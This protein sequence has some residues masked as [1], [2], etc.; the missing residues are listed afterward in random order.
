MDGGRGTFL[1]LF[2]IANPK[3]DMVEANK[4]AAGVIL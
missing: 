3:A 2:G 1:D 4:F